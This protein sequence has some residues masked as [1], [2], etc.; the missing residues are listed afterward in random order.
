MYLSNSRASIACWEE[1]PQRQ[2]S[3]SMMVCACSYGCIRQ[4]SL[5]QRWYMQPA[6]KNITSVCAKCLLQ[7]IYRYLI[8]HLKTSLMG[9]TS[10]VQQKKKFI[11]RSGWYG[12]RL[13]YVKIAE[14]FKMQKQINSPS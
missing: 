7:R 14:K 13:K 1:D 4:K 6:P 10:F 11:K 5:E 9:V 8:I 12:C 3:N 2:A